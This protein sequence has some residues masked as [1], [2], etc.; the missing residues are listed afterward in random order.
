VISVALKTPQEIRLGTCIYKTS[1]LHR[2]DDYIGFTPSCPPHI[3]QQNCAHAPQSIL[4]IFKN[5][6]NCVISKMKL[7][8]FSFQDIWPRKISYAVLPHTLTGVSH[9]A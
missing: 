1:L 5:W 8:P 4:K 6:K 3:L 7:P 2:S 9:V